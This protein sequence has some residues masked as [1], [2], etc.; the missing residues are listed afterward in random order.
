MH[1]LIFS[2]PPF[3]STLVPREILERGPLALEAYNKARSEGTTVVKR[4]PIMLIGQNRSGKTSLKK[5]LRG[6]P[7]DE[8]EKGTSG[9]DVDPSFF[10]VS[11]ELWKVGERDQ[12]ASPVSASLFD[13]HI[14]KSTVKNLSFKT[15]FEVGSARAIDPE[16]SDSKEAHTNLAPERSLTRMTSK[17]TSACEEVPTV[18]ENPD[19]TADS[20]T[21]IRPGPDIENDRE[22]KECLR[23]VTEMFLQ[24][25]IP[26]EEDVFSMFW[27]FGGESVY[28]T[29]H[30]IFLT[31]KA[32]YLLVH[33]LSK[34]ADALSKPVSYQ[35]RY[36]NYTDSHCLKQNV[37]YL[38]FWMSLVASLANHHDSDP[39]NT[40]SKT[41]PENLPPVFL[42]CTHADEPFG[43]SDATTLGRSVY[44][45]LKGK[46]SGTHLWKDFFVVDNTRSGKEPECSGVVHLRKEVRAAC[47]E[48]QKQ[49][50][51]IP[52]KWLLFETV[53]KEK[54]EKGFKF[55]SFEEARRTAAEECDICDKDQFRTLMKLLHDQRILIH[56]DETPELDR[57]VVLDC[58]WLI[59]VFKSVITVKPYEGEDNKFAGLWKTF[60]EE[61]IL[62]EELL[63]HVWSPLFKEQITCESLIAI[64]EKFSLLCSLPLSNPSHAREYLVPSMLMYLPSEDVKSL[65]ES[66]KIPSLF[67]K[68]KSGQVPPGLF[69]R[70][71]LEFF[72][73]GQENQSSQLRPSLHQNYFRF[74]LPEKRNCSFIL[75]SHSSSIEVVFHSVESADVSFVPKL[76]RQL[77]LV[78]TSMRIKF[79]WLKSMRYEIAFICPVCCQG[80]AVSFFCTHKIRG[81]KQ[82]ECLHFWLESEINKESNCTKNATAEDFSVHIEKFAPWTTPTEIRMSDF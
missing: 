3:T 47:N 10:K 78:L 17:E 23:N 12:D 26:N 34:D 27:D 48:L 56:F 77:E 43:R 16:D 49:G 35:G 57:L 22:S 37:D 15:K 74:Y 7:F 58:Q 2:F 21:H 61:G 67:I 62:K 82:E 55:I 53:M 51:A 75:L 1:S 72:P 19:K 64:M 65:V 80:K 24:K 14:A 28:Y 18:S 71:V 11:C 30:P 33:D 73:W 32:I 5:S 44:G 39:S 8:N 42:V 9:I 31:P 68:F 60:E 25:I 52:I 66:S 76:R 70:L 50:E 4:V 45:S 46:S 13:C 41:L 81:C 54:K 79:F 69:H 29:T 6:Q 20:S 59:D 38:Y 63:K 36:K 40:T